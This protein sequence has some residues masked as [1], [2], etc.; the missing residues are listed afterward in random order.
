MFPREIT[1]RG[2]SD[3]LLLHLYTQYNVV[4]TS[5]W[6]QRLE[7]LRDAREWTQE[8]FLG[9]SNCFQWSATI[10]RAAVILETSSFLVA[11]L[12]VSLPLATALVVMISSREVVVVGKSVGLVLGALVVWE[13]RSIDISEEGG[14]RVWVS[15]DT[16][17]VD[18]RL[19]EVWPGLQGLARALPASAARMKALRIISIVAT[20]VNNQNKTS[21]SISTPSTEI[22]WAIDTESS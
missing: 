6:L 2:V 8:S 12:A 19:D 18:R 9:V 1:A 11:G 5:T 4:P 3:C 16:V 21:I 13:V 15:L 20:V 14:M 7:K 10:I 17:P 22:R